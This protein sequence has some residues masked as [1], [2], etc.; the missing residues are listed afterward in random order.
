M[1]PTVV[2]IVSGGLI[3]DVFADAPAGVLILDR[4]VEGVSAEDLVMVGGRDAYPII[5]LSPEIDPEYVAEVKEVC[6]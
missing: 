4:D 5:W 2:V 3:V 6:K 1:K